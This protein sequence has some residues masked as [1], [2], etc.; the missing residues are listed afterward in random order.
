MLR[1]CFSKCFKFGV[2]GMKNFIF[3]LY[4]TLVDIKTDEK[5]PLFKKYIAKLF[6]DNGIEL[7]ED[8]ILPMY[9]QEY[10]K[11][12]PEPNAEPDIAISLANLM[13]AGGKEPTKELVEKIAWE[14]RKASHKKLKLYPEVPDILSTLRTRSA[15]IYLLSNAQSLFT[16]PEIKL[17][18]LEKY[19]DDICISSEFGF[20]K[21]DKRFFDHIIEKNG[22]NKQDCVFIGND[23]FTDIEGASNAGITS[24]YIRTETSSPDDNSVNTPYAIF[25]GN[26]NELKKMLLRFIEL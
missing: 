10:D 3:D 17:L 4:G 26:F 16:R 19:F 7:S 20:K 18:D 12:K 9:H 6:R 15:S 24:V 11:Q 5:D 14:W 1:P 13:R 25:D 8:E 21:P 23:K 22:L 2:C